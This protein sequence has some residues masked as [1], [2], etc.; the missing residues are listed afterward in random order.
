MLYMMVCVI[1][2]YMVWS[3]SLPSM[4]E[5]HRLKKENTPTL[6]LLVFSELFL[7]ASMALGHFGTLSF[8]I[9]ARITSAYGTRSFWL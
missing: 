8:S 2:G 9:Y 6:S 3:R 5:V 4:I 1:H 7:L